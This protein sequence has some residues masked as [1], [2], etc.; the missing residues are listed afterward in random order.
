MP[1]K[2]KHRH[3]GSQDSHIAPGASGNPG[4]RRRARAC[5]VSAVMC[6]AEYAAALAAR[7]PDISEPD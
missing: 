2:A 3:S 4:Y 7:W 1:G 6:I 5:L